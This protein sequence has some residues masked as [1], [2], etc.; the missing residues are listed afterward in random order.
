MPSS[1][2]GLVILATVVICVLG[3]AAIRTLPKERTPRVKLPVIVVV[4]P[5]PGAT[6]STNE[7]QIID[8]VEDEVEL[9]LD[10]L[11]DTGAVQSQSM[12][13][14]AVMQFI[15]ND[16]A[17]VLESKRDVESLINRVKGQ[18]PPEAQQDP[19]PIVSDIAFDQYPI[20][21]V[22][23]SGGQDGRHR[24]SVA[25]R[26]QTLI[27]KIAGV[28]SVDV[29]GGLEDEVQIDLDPHLMTL[30]GFSYQDVEGAIRRANSDAPSGSIE[31]GSGQ[32]QRVRTRGYARQ[33]RGDHTSPFGHAARRADLLRRRGPGEHGSQAT[34]LHGPL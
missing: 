1:C 31:S 14:A 33:Y 3:V 12:H 6:P 19:G 11:K 25:E 20:I 16:D 17:E 5:N 23:V 32:D 26:L 8:K 28:S 10:H 2:P 13:G 9:S 30:Y 7:K 34:N 27:E 15:F 24:R 18:F 22:F 29:F 4:V 21:Q